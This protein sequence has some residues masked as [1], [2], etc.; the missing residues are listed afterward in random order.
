MCAGVL[1]ENQS[2]KATMVLRT[3]FDSPFKVIVQTAR[4]AIPALTRRA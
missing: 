2:I 1:L 3:E 4:G